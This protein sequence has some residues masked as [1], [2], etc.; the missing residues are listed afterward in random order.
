MDHT[1]IDQIA[2]ADHPDDE[3][4]VENILRTL[5]VPPVI[6]LQAAAADYVSVLVLGGYCSVG[7]LQTLEQDHMVAVGIPPGHAQRI[8]RAIRVQEPQ[9]QPQPASQVPQVLPAS[10]AQAYQSSSSGKAAHY[11]P[12]YWCNSFWYIFLLSKSIGSLIIICW[13]LRVLLLG[14]W[15]QF[16]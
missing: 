11:K 6:S 15:L 7:A 8:L 14:L 4:A 16:D 3:E 5:L 13:H 1:L 10:V 12:S 2:L 9:V